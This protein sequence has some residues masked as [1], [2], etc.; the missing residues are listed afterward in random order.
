MANI[1]LLALVDCKPYHCKLML[2]V[3]V[4]R[5]IKGTYIIPNPPRGK[6]MLQNAI[7]RERIALCIG[8]KVGKQRYQD[9]QTKGNRAMDIE[10]RERKMSGGEGEQS[11]EAA[12][13]TY[14]ILR[15][16]RCDHLPDKLQRI[17]GPFCSLAYDMAT[18]LPR[19]AETS[20]ALRKLL[21]G[22]DAA[23]RAEVSRR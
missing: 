3:C 6:K 7:D 19:C 15:F 2:A 8:C 11:K 13:I 21:E 9:T 1:K 10:D 18:V 14:H 23:V 16:F 17:S 12:E 20:V 22:K 5:W 4:K